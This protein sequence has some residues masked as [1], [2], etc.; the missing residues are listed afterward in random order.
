M[1][2]PAQWTDAQIV[3]ACHTHATA[4]PEHPD[5]V[6]IAGEW[7]D[8]QRRTKT[9]TTARWPAPLKHLIEAWGLRYVTEDDVTTAARLLCLR[10]R[11][12][13]FNIRSELTLPS[14]E[15]LCGI[16]EAGAHPGY[17]YRARDEHYMRRA[18]FTQRQVVTRIKS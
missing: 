2:R 9:T 12:P 13:F 14:C 11:Y 6:R 15:R 1:T 17:G 10:G 16:G 18:S 5:C 8:A 7:L 4:L 3:A